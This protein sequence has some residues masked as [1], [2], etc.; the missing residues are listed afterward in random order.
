VA[1]KARKEPAK[2]ATQAILATMTIGAAVMVTLAGG[3]GVGTH[4]DRAKNTDGKVRKQMMKTAMR[5]VATAS[6]CLVLAA[7]AVSPTLATGA[8][9]GRMT[10]GK[11][12][13]KLVF[14]SDRVWGRG[15]RNPEG[16]LEIFAMGPEGKK[17]EQLTSNA[18]DDF[19][20]AF[21][22]D[23]KISYVSQNAQPS[24][25]EGDS[26]VYL[27][28]ADGT[29]PRNLTNT[30]G[31]VSDQDPRFSADGQDL[32]FTSF[33]KQ[34][35][36]PEGDFEVYLMKADGSGQRNLTNNALLSEF[37][38]DFSSDGREIA[39]S[40]AG[41]QPSNPEGDF[42]IYLMDA[43]GAKQRNVTNTAGSI[44]D[45][46]AA[47]SPD[48]RT[49]AYVSTGVQPSNPEGD[50]EVFAIDA[51]G[52]G[53]QNLTDTAG[54]VQDQ[55]PDFATDGTKIAYDSY[56][57]QP[58]N[59]EG[60]TEVYVMDAL[61]GGNQRNLTRTGGDVSDVQPDLEGAVGD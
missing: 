42:E 26:E 2:K 1:P 35:S 50:D 12:A 28:D 16:D 48:G 56:G 10:G 20:P 29:N 17:L 22:S 18:V 41:V 55:F 8:E 47:L 27:M 46:D 58:S 51:D 9:A 61:D 40:S 13:E 19:D 24:N 38:S 30:A 14:A 25:P 36:N 3:A 59:P 44:S 7:V 39:F 32:A 37:A 53:R 33:G 5:T 15:T 11:E 34:P 21:S 23:G 52:S 49:V 57:A 6:S 43:D 31:A 4:F 54:D 60:D 45:F